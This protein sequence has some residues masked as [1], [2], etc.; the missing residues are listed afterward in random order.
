MS[1]ITDVGVNF[2][3]QGGN[4]FESR[5]K[6][7]ESQWKSFSASMN[8]APEFGKHLEK[9]STHLEHT[10]KKISN[11]LGLIKAAAVGILAAKGGGEIFNWALGS[12]AVAKSKVFAETHMDNLSLYEQYFSEIR[13]KH[14]VSRDDLIRGAFE[15]NSA[16]STRP[17]DERIEAFKSMTYYMSELGGSFVQATQFYK[18]MMAAFAS[19]LPEDQKKT[20]AKD[21]LGKLNQ[22]SRD[23]SANPDEIAQALSKAGPTYAAKGWS[24]DDL[25]AHLAYLIPVTGSSE[26]AGNTLDKLADRAPQYSGALAKNLYRENYVR[27]QIEGQDRDWKSYEALEFAAKQG[28]EIARRD[29]AELAAN[30]KY[31]G[32]T[33]KKHMEELLASK[34]PQ[35]VYEHLNQQIETL[36]RSSKMSTSVLEDVFGEY[37]SKVQKFLGG[38]TSGEIDRLKKGGQKSDGQA[39]MDQ[40]DAA[41]AKQLPELWGLVKQ[42][43][44]DFSG[45]MRAVFYEPMRALLEEWKMVF[46]KLEKD[47]TGTSGMKKIQGFGG[48]LVTGFREGRAQG[49]VLPED[50]RSVGQMFQDFVATLGPDDFRNAGKM[51]GKAASDFVTVTSQLK[52]IIAVVHKTLSGLAPDNKSERSLTIPAAIGWLTS[53]F[54]RNPLEKLILGGAGFMGA[55]YFVNGPG[56]KS[57]SL[58]TFGL[59]GIPFQTNDLT[60]RPSSGSEQIASP[61]LQSPQGGWGLPSVN[62]TSQPQ[63]TINMDDRAIKD[64][65][66]VEVKDEIQEEL[67]KENDRNRANSNDKPLMGQ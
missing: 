6:S 44:E 31:A 10:Q 48:E 55:D 29:M 20:F 1:A 65:I 15:I 32:D 58:K 25:L 5:L 54:G 66:K 33:A 45:S 9:M 63:V 57:E 4:E 64:A 21:F 3:M 35:K 39:V 13:D 2:K 43:S 34:Q 42:K 51:I 18:K 26:V 16:L 8:Q 28:N 11:S 40:T 52:D 60:P 56:E 46:Q 59:K 38:Y 50:N 24:I 41:K 14:Q 27:G 62:I 17:E 36:K 7:L 23:S 47:F 22:I 37:S 30:E 53:K 49:Q 61:R 19:S 12:E 67:L